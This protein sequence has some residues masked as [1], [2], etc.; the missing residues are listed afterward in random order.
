MQRSFRERSGGSLRSARTRSGEHPGSPDPG[1][2]RADA[3]V[4]RFRLRQSGPSSRSVRACAEPAPP[5][6]LGRGGRMAD[7]Q[8]FCVAEERSGHCA[9]VDGHFLYV[10]GG[11][12][13]R[14]R[15]G[16]AGAAR[17]RRLGDD[18]WRRGTP[19][20]RLP[21]GSPAQRTPLAAGRPWSLRLPKPPTRPGSQGA[22]LLQPRWRRTGEDPQD[23]VPG[24]TVRLLPRCDSEYPSH[25]AVN[26]ISYF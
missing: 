10:W 23:A 25:Q 5:S 12:V 17:E 1:G 21:G 22:W 3:Q 24:Y 20:R 7:S 2:G 16:R 13:V 8:A 11:Y 14:G 6:W 15:G 18:G 4:P 19:P 9:V 26:R